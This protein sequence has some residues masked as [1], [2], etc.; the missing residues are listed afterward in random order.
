MTDGDTTEPAWTAHR[1][2]FVRDHLPPPEAQPLYIFDIDEVRYP[3][4]L[5]AGAELI[6]RAV[7]RGWGER[8]AVLTED[9]AWTYAQ[10]KQA[11][12]RY[13]QVLV[14]DLGLVPGGRVLLRAPNS[15]ELVAL[16]LAVLRAGGV[17]VTTM[18]LLREAELAPV[19]AKGRI[20]MAVCADDLAQDLEQ[21]RDG[22]QPDL[23][24]L[25]YGELE[26]RA[27]DKD[28]GFEPIRTHRDDPCMLAFTS[29]TT[30][31]PKACIH[32]HRDVLAMADTFARFVLKPEIDDVFAAT[33]PIAFTFGL[34]GAVVFP[35]RFGCA[36][37]FPARPGV[38]ALLDHIS[39][40]RVSVLFTAPTSYRQM[41]A[42][43]EWP[44]LSALRK[45]VSAGEPLPQ[46]TSDAWFERTGLRPI[47]G[48]GSTEMIH[49]FISASGDDI[50]P[51]ATG[52]PVPGFRAAILD[53]DG[54][55]L[56]DDQV[57]RLA[58]RGPTGCRYLDDERQAKYVQHGWN[59]TGDS[60]RRDADGYYW[61]VARSDDMII[62]SGYNIAAPEVEAAVLAYPDVVECAVV[63]LPDPDRG[64]LVK[65]FVVLRERPADAAAFAKG[66]QD[67][68]KSKIAPYKYPRAV[69]IVDELPKTATGKL[70][71][72][73]L[74]QPGGEG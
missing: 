52:R 43:A 55:E 41:L 37:S 7:E 58:V 9:G 3:Q 31:Q 29:G 57:G 49:I 74:K 50:R 71:R 67:F 59:V 46:A 44:D 66:L 64:S 4:A 6:D 38:G 21:V 2:T 20:G 56:G 5:N 68:V 70:Q 35:L 26:A 28:G 1:D 47:D 65:A 39:R 63:G 54:R 33:P 14:E 13:A 61:F 36:M 8:R 18:P 23:R 42:Q 25:T 12:D 72:F 53:E 73:R 60:Y 30:G 40:H 10:L 24:V 11:S 16:W 17:V 51:G 32:F 34:G 69:E 15:A 48:I 22:G 19:I 27:A 45:C 62:S